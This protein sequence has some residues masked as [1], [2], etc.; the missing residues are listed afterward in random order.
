METLEA[1]LLEFEVRGLRQLREEFCAMN[2]NLEDGVRRFK[3]QVI[4][5]LV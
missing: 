3:L 5:T 4:R 2:E 1:K